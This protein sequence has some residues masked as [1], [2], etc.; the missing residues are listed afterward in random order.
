MNS[1]EFILYCTHTT[2]IKTHS[3]LLKIKEKQKKNKN[4][5]KFR[6]DLKKNH[7]NVFVFILKLRLYIDLCNINVILKTIFGQLDNFFGL[8]VDYQQNKYLNNKFL[9]FSFT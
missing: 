5:K 3:H 6:R 4:D 7:C 9:L 1:G 2:V 8:S